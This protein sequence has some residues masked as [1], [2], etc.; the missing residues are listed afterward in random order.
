MFNW[1]FY[2]RFSV[3]YKQTKIVKCFQQFSNRWEKSVRHTMHKRQL[4]FKHPSQ[5]LCC[6]Y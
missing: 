1:Q 3:C 2:E 5:I 6:M 4:K